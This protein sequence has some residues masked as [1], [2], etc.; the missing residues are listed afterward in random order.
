MKVLLEAPILTKSGYGEH[1]RLVHESLLSDSSLDIYINPL[2]W[3]TCSWEKPNSLVSQSI[4]KF[5]GYEEHCKKSNEKPHYDVQIH[6]GIPNEFQ[7]KAPYSVCVTAGIETDRISANW[8]FK[9]NQGIDKIIVPSEH[10]RTGFV[11]TGY[12][13]INNANN[14]K[15]EISCGCLVET[16]PYPV[17]KTEPASLD[18]NLETDFNYLQVAMIGFRKNLDTSIRCFVEEFRDEENVGLILKVGLSKSTIIDRQ[19]TKHNIKA[20]IDSLGPRKC[21][22]YLI[23]GNLSEQELHSLYTHPKVKAYYTTTHGEGYGL[24]IFEAAYSGLPVIAT[25]WSGHLD[26]LVGK[27]SGKNKKLFAKIDFELKK[28][29][30]QAV[31]KDIVIEES[32]WA[33]VKE[34][35]VKRQLR[36]VYKNY[37]RYKNWAKTLQSQIIES[38]DSNNILNKMQSSILSKKQDPEPK[39]VNGISFC[40]S[41]NASKVEKTL[42]QIKSI[43]NTMAES[44]LPYEIIVAGVTQPFSNDNDLI[45]VDTPED[46][47]SGLLAKLRN[48]AGEKV[49]H[50]TIV[51]VDDDFIFPSS[52]ATRLI[53]FSSNNG[54]DILGNKILLPDGSRFWDRATMHPHKLVSYDHPDIIN[55]VYQTGGFWIMRKETYSVHKW[56]GDIP[57]NAAERGISN[58]NEDIEMSL[59]MHV[60]GIKFVFDKENTVWHYDNSYFEFNEQTLKRTVLAEQFGDFMLDIPDDCDEFSSVMEGLL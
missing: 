50:D 13:V 1:A 26:F 18:L 29:Q 30:K 36:D 42:L 3:G 46:A 10:A 24:P 40:I 33:F 20:F 4:N 19:K 51:F 12:E 22:I 15:T 32:R 2:N 9:T 59:R 16:V 56:N 23:H 53:E 49:N 54:W 52:W 43:K 27:V 41:T 7:K 25:D 8:V 31:W 58:Y 14:T 35:S 17:K 28:V 55:A 37:G 48:N 11:K 57:I 45:L 60:N 39:S 34:K 21:K 44:S 6:V 47:N 5:K 38:H